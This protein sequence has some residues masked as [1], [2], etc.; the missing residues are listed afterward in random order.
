MKTNVYS[1]EGKKVRE[2]EL[3][4][5]FKKDY[6]PKLIAR[7]VIASESEDFQ[8][9][10]NNP[11]AGMDTSAEY[12]GRRRNYRATIG[13]GEAHLP[14]IKPGG[15]G[16]G[17]V[18]KVPQAI[19]GRRAHPPKVEKIIV[20][21][22]NRKEKRAALQSSIAAT[23]NKEIVKNRGYSLEEVK[24]LPLVIENKFQDVKKTKEALD[25]LKKIGLKPELEKKKR[26]VIIAENELKSCKN[27][28]GVEVAKATSL[29]ARIFAP[30]T[31]AG[32]LTV[33]TEAAL[34]RAG[35]VYGD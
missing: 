33:W 19:G 16:R 10:G 34:K 15:G 25:I 23:A 3:P 27:I 2:I 21:K 6:N 29:N 35:E 30:G 7:A 14:K 5:I 1:I 18:R 12:V 17:G 22:I 20:K 32:V 26:I 31:H 24:E 8:P 4:Q 9:H 28:P 11:R 13:S